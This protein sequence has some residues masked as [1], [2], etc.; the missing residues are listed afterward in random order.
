MPPLPNLTPTSS[1]AD[2]REHLMLITNNSG[3]TILLYG[4]PVTFKNSE[5]RNNWREW[6]VRTRGLSR[7]RNEHW[8]N[9]AE[10]RC[11]INARELL[12]EVGIA[13]TM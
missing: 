5:H 12:S 10:C 3:G 9:G 6:I 4:H 7:G 13:L 1:A 11:R 2:I 8:N